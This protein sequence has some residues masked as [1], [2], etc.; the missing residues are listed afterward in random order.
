MTLV[1]SAAAAWA[2]LCVGLGG[3]ACMPGKGKEKA[4]RFFLSFFPA[5]RRFGFMVCSEK[6]MINNRTLG[7]K[8]YLQY[9]KNPW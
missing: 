2:A 9:S 6:E 1:S 5:V 4:S 3:W 7:N 8:K